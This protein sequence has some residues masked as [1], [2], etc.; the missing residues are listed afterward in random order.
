MLKFIAKRILVSIPI[1][2]A[3]TIIT[4]F[5][6]HAAPGDPADILMNPRTKPEERERIRKNLGLDKPV[7]VQ[8]GIWLKNL[9]TKG[10]MGYS[11]VTG[12]PVKKVIMEKI[13]A[14]L[15]LMG[16][17]Y[18]L[19]LALSIPLGVWSA[20]RKNT[21]FDYLLTFFSFF[22][23]S[24]PSFWLALMAIFLFTQ[25]LGWFPSLGM[26]SVETGNWWTKTVNI[27]WH[28]FLPM[29]VLTI[30][31]L[32]SW[33]RYLRSSMIE[34]LQE[35]YIRT[36]RAFGIPEDDITFKYALKPASLPMLTLIGLSL[37]QVA[38]GSFV[39]EFL[40][41]WPGIG[42]LGIEAIMKRDFSVIMGDI[43]IASVLIILGNLLADLLYGWFD[44]RIR[45]KD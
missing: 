20:V 7:I 45:V 38:A 6:I 24:V 25:K 22:G 14:T 11:L 2:L 17:S 1:L 31:N 43:L 12:R 3:V 32:A 8:Y 5:L 41:G 35:D 13:P 26:I 34:T 18:I 28:L 30:R 36:A 40:F 4:F 44:P 37:P 21:F 15:L 16:S 27:M 10:D 39:I 42:R 33:T 19:S 29:M 23:L 9:V